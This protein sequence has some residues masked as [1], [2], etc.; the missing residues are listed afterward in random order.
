MVSIYRR[1]NQKNLSWSQATG[2]GN[3][4]RRGDYRPQRGGLRRDR[5]QHCLM[6]PRLA[7]AAG[8]GHHSQ[9]HRG[10]PG[11]HH[12]QGAQQGRRDQHGLRP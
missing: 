6:D 9:E 4:F 5:P 10:H 2:L 3:D 12:G 7:Q 1:S 8:R 11:V